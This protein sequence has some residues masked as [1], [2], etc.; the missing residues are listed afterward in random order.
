MVSIIVETHGD[1]VVECQEGTRVCRFRTSRAV[2]SK[3]SP[4][5][6]GLICN[7]VQNGSRPRTIHVQEDLEDMQN[8]LLAL[9]K[10]PVSVDRIFHA[11]SLYRLARL[12][13][14]YKCQLA[15][16][17]ALENWSLHVLC[18]AS[19]PKVTTQA[20]M[21][22]IAF[23]AGMNEWFGQATRYVLMNW[24]GGFRELF[25]DRHEGII[26]DSISGT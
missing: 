19:Y 23:L 9:H 2:L 11:D 18:R 17:P 8:L 21:V 7:S 25:E 16:Q 15:I 1:M 22:V 20:S 6:A 10:D 24:N 5:F 26:P 13:Q 12:S 4:V 3:K 14:T